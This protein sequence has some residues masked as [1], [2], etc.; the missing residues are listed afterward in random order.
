[1]RKSWFWS[2]VSPLSAAL[3]LAAGLAAAAG[4][5]T[6]VERSVDV[7]IHP[8]GVHEHERLRV[9][10]ESADDLESWSSYPIYLDD[11][12]SLERVNA[13]AVLPD[14]R[15][16]KVRRRDR[17]TMEY[18][19]SLTHTSVR[20]HLLEFS[21]LTVGAELHVDYEIE[22]EP[23]FPAAQIALTGGDAVERLE[24]RVSGGDDA[25]RW[26]IDGPS[27]GFEVEQTAGG[28]VV[29]ASGLPEIDPPQYSPGG[30]AV[31]P[32]LRY[33]WGREGSWREVGAWY[34]DL[35][36]AL[37]RG[38]EPVRGQARELLAG[39]DDPRKRFEALVEF[40][41]RKV[42]YVAVEVGIGGHRPSPPA[43]VLERK[44]GDCKDKALL[45]VDLL[46]EAGIDAYPALIRLGSSSRVDVEF[47]SLQ[48]NHM[49][50]A[51]PGA[52]L[53]AG[54]G[55]PVGDGYFF[56]DPTQERGSAGWLH[57]GVQDQR[58]LVVRDGSGALAHTPVLP[59]VERRK[60]QVTLRL[61][62]EGGALGGAGLQLAGRRATGYLE[63]IA[64]TPP[65]RTEEIARSI[66]ASLLPGVDV[67]TVGW[68]EG[69]DGVPTVDLSA[70]VAVETL[71]DGVGSRPSF[72]L[73]GLETTPEPRLLDERDVPLVV[74][75]QVSEMAWDLILP[76]GWC[77]P[78]EKD[79]RLE[80]SVGVVVNSVA[81]QDGRIRVERRV[82]LKRRW[83]EP[84]DFPQLR[85]LALAERRAQRRRI[86]LECE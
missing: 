6:V 12:R 53:A 64:S 34:A 45:L 85:E 60:L 81:F 10:L 36:A 25:W 13:G 21:G 32:V 73:V 26:R 30:A 47:P 51:V 76:E 4:A 65:E 52:E 55:D 16:I 18:S 57:P 8:G 44:W 58:A 70:A 46:S 50:V 59:E 80:N 77:P 72:R 67:K 29:R 75:P 69:D 37:P 15:E 1:M 63:R 41:R 78:E 82:E 79:D 74:W 20:Y 40:L 31:Y 62:P 43:E 61:T 23:Y 33:G 2:S 38:S 9:R 86:R 71:V 66:F 49:I 28:V 7:T 83:I 54:D 22:E 17:D 5:A 56:V 68:I 84:G 14:G 39:L 24:V 3:A 19:G 48:F 42:R 35:I 11:H 27:D